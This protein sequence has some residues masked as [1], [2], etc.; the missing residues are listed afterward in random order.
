MYRPNINSLNYLIFKNEWQPE[1]FNNTLNFG[2][3]HQYRY[4][5]GE[6]NLNVH[7]RTAAFTNDYNFSTLA[8]TSVNKNRIGKF[9]FNTRFFAQYGVATALPDESALF[10]YGSNPEAMM[11]NKFTRSAGFF[12][13]GWSGFGNS[14]NHFH[15]GGGLN[16]RGYS[17]YLAPFVDAD[18]NLSF[19]YKGLSGASVNAELGFDRLLTLMPW[20]LRNI[21]KFH[22]YLFADA[23]IV[24]ANMGSSLSFAPFRADAGIGTALTIK[25]WGPLQMVNPLT[26]RFD[27]PLWLNRTPDTD[28]NFFKMR[29]VVGINRAF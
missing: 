17:G 6:G 15:H 23:G 4:P 27:M 19:G 21:F 5:K 1:K 29:W 3:D 14:I 16:L 10:I 26:I 13:T 9:D 20:K 22:S 2:V 18:D 11:D 12:P 28:P 7:M 25:K 8:L 24:S